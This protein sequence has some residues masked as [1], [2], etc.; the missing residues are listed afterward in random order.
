MRVKHLSHN[1][2]PR[3][4]VLR[5]AFRLTAYIFFHLFPNKML[6]AVSILNSDFTNINNADVLSKKL[7]VCG[8]HI[9]GAFIR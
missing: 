5:L 2:Y 1:F 3:F 4:S 8:V 7:D 6:P 9:G